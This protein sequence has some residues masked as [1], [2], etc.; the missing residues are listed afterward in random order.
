V[1]HIESKEIQLGMEYQEESILVPPPTQIVV[2][3]VSND[4]R[5]QKRKSAS[6]NSVREMHPTEDIFNILQVQSSRSYDGEKDP[7]QSMNGRA[8]FN[9]L[10]NRIH[11][12]H[13]SGE[14]TLQ[15]TQKTDLVRKRSYTNA[16]DL[17]K[18]HEKSSKL[19]EKK[20]EKEAKKLEKKEEEKEEERR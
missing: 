18:E 11:I 15:G 1:N 7:S 12:L 19:E 6:L 20:R 8:R 5:K 17:R 10:R 2:A 14:D 4:L 16:Q 9:S 3:P 13:T